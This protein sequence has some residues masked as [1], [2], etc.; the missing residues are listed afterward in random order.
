MGGGWGWGWDN[1]VP[2]CLSEEH[3]RRRFRALY[4]LLRQLRR[5]ERHRRVLKPCFF[6]A[7]EAAGHG[8]KELSR[9]VNHCHDCLRGTKKNG[10]PTRERLVPQGYIKQDMHLLLL[11]FLMLQ[12]LSVVAIVS[13]IAIAECKVGGWPTYENS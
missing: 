3:V 12:S 1:D 7:F 13:N 10:A 6:A 4:R 2:T 11:L 8:A 9:A 5:V